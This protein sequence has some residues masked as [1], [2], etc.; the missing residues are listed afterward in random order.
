MYPHSSAH[1]GS[2]KLVPSSVEATFQI[3]STSDAVAV[4]QCGP[5]IRDGIGNINVS[6]KLW[7]RKNKAKSFEEAK[8]TNSLGGFLVVT[9]T[10]QT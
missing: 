5:I 2:T 6:I 8:D 3:D 1:E 9:A 10:Y 4:L 7:G